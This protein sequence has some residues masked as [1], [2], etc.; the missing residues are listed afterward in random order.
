[1]RY[2]VS[3]A[4]TL[5]RVCFDALAVELC[6]EG[7][8]SGD[9]EALGPGFDQ[10]QCIIECAYASTCLDLDWSL[11]VGGEQFDIIQSRSA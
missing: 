3:A 6:E 5:L 7:T 10:C 11:A 1:M 2:I 4:L 9:P 8:G